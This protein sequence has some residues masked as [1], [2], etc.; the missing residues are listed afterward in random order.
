MIFL[1]QTKL[2]RKKIYNRTNENFF[3]CVFLYIEK[4]RVRTKFNNFLY[5]KIHN[6]TKI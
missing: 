4:I 5:K 6:R 3:E 1:V 2:I